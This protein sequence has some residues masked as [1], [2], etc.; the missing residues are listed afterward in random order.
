MA[1][2]YACCGLRKIFETDAQA[3]ARAGHEGRGSR[4][5]GS[6]AVVHGSVAGAG[7]LDDAR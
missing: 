6:S 5:P 3:D 1:D 4:P 7:Q 2:H